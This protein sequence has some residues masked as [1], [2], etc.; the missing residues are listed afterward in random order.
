MGLI[1]SATDDARE[2]K[3]IEGNARRSRE[4]R[5]RRDVCAK[6]RKMRKGIA[7]RREGIQIKRT[8]EKMVVLS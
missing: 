8:R 6:Q 3:N 7:E 2:K 5:T 4:Q 1:V